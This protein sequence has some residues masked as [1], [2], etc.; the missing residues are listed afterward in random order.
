MGSYTTRSVKTKL[1]RRRKKA[2]IKEQGRQWYYAT[3]KLYIACK[4]SGILIEPKCKFWVNASVKSVPVVS[5]DG[6][7]TMI[8]KPTRYW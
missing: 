2:A 6:T 5:H 7:P 3:I 4:K 8:P 1:P